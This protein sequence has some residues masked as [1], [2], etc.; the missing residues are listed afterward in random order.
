MEPGIEP[1]PG[2]IS[3]KYREICFRRSKSLKRSWC[4]IVSFKEDCK[5]GQWHE[6]SKTGTIFVWLVLTS[7]VLAA[8]CVVACCFLVLFF[9]L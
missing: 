7:L 2:L 8:L 1:G 5:F 3:P 4:L 9:S 6:R